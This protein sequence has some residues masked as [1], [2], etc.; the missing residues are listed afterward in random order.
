MERI[1]AKRG[2]E[3]ANMES[4]W[5]IRHPIDVSSASNRWWPLPSHEP[6][7][8]RRSK[9]S[10]LKIG[11]VVVS[12]RTCDAKPDAKTVWLDTWDVPLSERLETSG[13]RLDSLD[14]F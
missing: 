9:F 11:T 10:F 13:L 6:K 1:V 4:F 8:E 12:F 5:A 3:K 2:D 14:N 7:P